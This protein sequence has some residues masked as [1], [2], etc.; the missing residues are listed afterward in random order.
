MLKVSTG[1]VSKVYRSEST[2]K[3]EYSD[4][5]R[6]RVKWREWSDWAQ[7]GQ[8]LKSRMSSSNEFGAIKLS[9]GSGP[10]ILATFSD[11]HIGAWG[12]DYREFERMTN[13][14]MTTPNLYIA[15]V[16]DYVEF[17]IKLRSVLETTSQ[18]F[19]PE[20]QI[21]FL[22]DWLMEIKPKVAF[23]TWDNHA[24][25]REERQSG[26]S[27]VKRALAKNVMYF[28]GIGHA[29]IQVGKQVYNIAASHRFKQ[30]SSMLNPCASMQRYMRFE[31]ID[32]EICIQGD[33]HKPGMA[34]YRDGNKLRLCLNA[35]TLHV[36]SGYAKR[37]FSLFSAPDFP[38]V[39]LYPDSHTFTPFWSV[40]E[41]SKYIA[42]K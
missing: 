34:Q 4:K 39:V 23:A 37:Y 36:N 24:V 13:E 29:D 11:T 10:I 38:C 30:G 22:E 35:G 27:S 17:A 16:G 12:C 21:E 7:K 2:P 15:L 33:T 19:T 20:Q 25:E 18:V 28:N 5:K 8:E 32:R 40:A 31:G 6:G 26:V 14:L 9:D 3:V 41:A 42:G 1:T